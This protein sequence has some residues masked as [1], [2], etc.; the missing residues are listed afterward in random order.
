MTQD[1][2]PQ[3]WLISPLPISLLGALSSKQQLA[4]TAWVPTQLRSRVPWIRN[5]R[6]VSI[7]QLQTAHK[8]KF[9]LLNRKVIEHTWKTVQNSKQA[10]V[11]AKPRHC[12]KC[13]F[14]GAL[15]TWWLPESPAG[16]EGTSVEVVPLK[17]ELH[18][19]SSPPR[20]AQAQSLTQPVLAFENLGDFISNS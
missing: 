9:F 14:W 3:S 17:G 13:P 6:F 10:T 1:F 18:A 5:H 15:L 12:Q 4:K 19:T 2:Y 16:K 7:S 11:T 20:M 8:S